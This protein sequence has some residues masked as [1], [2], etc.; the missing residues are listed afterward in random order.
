MN[1]ETTE[2]TE[3]VNISVTVTD[4][5]ENGLNN[6]EVTLVDTND[7]TNIFTG[8]TGTAGGCN[9]TNVPVGTYNVSVIKTGYNNYPSVL[10][11]TSETN[12]LHI[13]MTEE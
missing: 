2:P 3:N 7:N 13:E 8:S 5:N 11:V 1:P 10:T 12:S 6:V 4:D 9:L